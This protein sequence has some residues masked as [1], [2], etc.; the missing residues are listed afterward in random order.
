[1]PKTSNSVEVSPTRIGRNQTAQVS[2]DPHLAGRGL[3]DRHSFV[4]FACEFLPRF[5][6]R[7]VHRAVDVGLHGTRSGGS[8]DIA[9]V[10]IFQPR[11]VERKTHW[12]RCDRRD[13]IGKL[14]DHRQ[15]DAGGSLVHGNDPDGAGFVC[16]RDHSNVP[17]EDNPNEPWLRSWHW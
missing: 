4:E 1:M 5:V 2:S 12:G 11:P 13:W 3:G 10:V 16:D 9:L 17:N 7:C 14:S 6:G 15:I 8:I